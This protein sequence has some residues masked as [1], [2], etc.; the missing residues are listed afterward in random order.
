MLAKYSFTLEHLLQHSVQNTLAKNDV[1]KFKH[2][3]SSLGRFQCQ[4]NV[5]HL[6]RFKFDVIRFDVNISTSET[7]F[8]W[9]C[10]RG[11]SWSRRIH[12]ASSNEKQQK[13]E[14]KKEVSFSLH[15]KL[16]PSCGPQK[17]V[18]RPSFHI[19]DDFLLKAPYYFY[20]ISLVKFIAFI[21]VLG[22]I[23]LCN[24]PAGHLRFMSSP[25]SN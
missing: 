2:L 4:F 11:R 23:I 5:D 13:Q 17:V 14:E 25:I 1:I 19:V 21:I 15:V 10:L 6:W 24:V 12:Q 3:S 18:C 22:Y 16:K 7:I 9:I 8:R 20:I